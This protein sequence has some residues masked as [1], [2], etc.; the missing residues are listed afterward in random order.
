MTKVSRVLFCFLA[1]SVILN[2]LMVTGILSVLEQNRELSM[3]TSALILELDAVKSQLEYYRSQA[4]Y[5]SSLLE[6]L[7]AGK[8]LVGESAINVV[9]VKAVRTGLLETSYMGVTMTCRVELKDGSGRVLINTVPYI[10]IDLQTSS[11]TAA[12][13]AENLTEAQ[14]GKTDIIITIEAQESIE[15]VD[16]PSAGAAITIAIVAA[17]NNQILNDTIFIT[18]TINPDGTIGM[19]GGLIEKAEAVAS[20]NATIFL[21]PKGQSTVTIYQPI[22]YNPLPGVTIIKYEETQ[23]DLEAYLKQKGYDTKVIEVE[24]V[25]EA[26][27]FFTKL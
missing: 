27:Q 19:V 15:I 17:I 14:L 13:V 18:G 16:G 12:L 20:A 26:Y 8:S 25:T 1:V 3:K 5:Y 22:R 9:A 10:G 6:S 2:G 11:R 7:E 21:V 23:I 4:E 24:N